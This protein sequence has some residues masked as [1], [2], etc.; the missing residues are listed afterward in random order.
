[1]EW[2]FISSFGSSMYLPETKY[3]ESESLISK[4]IQSNLRTTM[5][6][7]NWFYYL[8]TIRCLMCN[9]ISEVNGAAIDSD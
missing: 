9:W 6:N 2:K 5:I 1:M 8:I 7:N 4:V 3:Y